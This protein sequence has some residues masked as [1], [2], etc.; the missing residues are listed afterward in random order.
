MFAQRGNLVNWKFL[1]MLRDIMRFNRI[2]TSIAAA[3]AEAEMM[4]P[5]GDFLK[6]RKFSVEFRDW[7]FLPMMGC[8][9]SA[10]P[11]RCWPSRSPP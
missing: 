6:A 1:R 11:T 5:L 7:Y 9:W 10:R 3:N 8:I 4:Q 2:T